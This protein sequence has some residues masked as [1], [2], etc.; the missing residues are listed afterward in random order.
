MINM[1]I[2]QQTKTRLERSKHLAG[3]STS[4]NKDAVSQGMTSIYGRYQQEKP[5][6]QIKAKTNPGTVWVVYHT[7]DKDGY[8][9]LMGEEVE[10]IAGQPKELATL[11]IPSGDYQKFTL[12][13]PCNILKDVARAWNQINSM[14]SAQLGG[15]R[16]FID[17]EVY[18]ARK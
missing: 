4:I 16:T 14:T 9:C 11:T 13:A 1:I 10:D 8:Q 12:Y 17:F 3:I 7:H 15:K 18:D 6:E 5:E 2:L